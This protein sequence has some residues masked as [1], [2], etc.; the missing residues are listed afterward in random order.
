[1]T[2]AEDVR[3]LAALA[4]ITLT[5]EE[6][7]RFSKEF[8]SILEYAG[9]VEELKIPKDMNFKPVVSNVLREDGQ[10]DEKGT[11]TKKIVEQFPNKE[12]NTLKVA[13]IISYE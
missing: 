12:G 1:M 9:Q 3:K 2:S 4:R 7:E 11:H 5:D 6:V 13:Q 8:D 10:P